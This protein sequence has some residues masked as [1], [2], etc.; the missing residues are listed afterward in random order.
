[1]LAGFGD[2]G[3]A[4]S[5]ISSTRCRTPNRADGFPAHAD[6]CSRMYSTQ[7]AWAAGLLVL[8]HSTSYIRCA[9]FIC[10]GCLLCY[11]GLRY[12]QPSY[13]APG[14]KGTCWHACGT[15]GLLPSLPLTRIDNKHYLRIRMPD[16]STCMLPASRPLDLDLCSSLTIGLQMSLL[17]TQGTVQVSGTGTSRGIR[18]VTFTRHGALCRERQV[19]AGA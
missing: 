4:H 12:A 2:C 9:W 8:V 13:R 16:T 11:S 10:T 6:T 14:R 17:H 15:T 7:E 3:G 18:H 19:E 5:Q 1:M